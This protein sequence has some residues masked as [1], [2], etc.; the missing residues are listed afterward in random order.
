MLMLCGLVMTCGYAPP[1]GAAEQSADPDLI[2]HSASEYDYPPFS[3]IDGNGRPGGFSVDLFTAAVR[4][5]GRDV[6]FHVGPWAEVKEM[7]KSGEVDALPLVGRTPEREAV[8]DFTFP[9]LSLHGAIVVRTGEDQIRDLDDL[10]G[11]D[12]A[13]MKGDNAEEFLR[14]FGEDINISTTATFEDA[15]RE[16]SEGRHDAVV[17]QRLVALRLIR[18]AGITNLS[19]INKPL[20]G[21][22]QDFCFAVREGD[23]ET[24]ALLNEGLSL[25][26]ADGTFRYLNAKWFAALELP[27]NQR[28]VV[29]GDRNFPPFEFLDEH[30]LPAGYNVEITRAIARELGLDIEIRL[31]DWGEI[32]KGLASGA[33]DA[34]QGM[35]Y[36]AERDLEFDFS[37]PHTV[38]NYVA[39]VRKGTGDPPASPD[40]LTGK[41]LV[42]M[43]GDIMHDLALKQGLGG[44]VATV[45]SQEDALREL[46]EG[47]H[48]C[49]LVA[50][51]PAMYWIEKNGWD[52]LLVGRHSLISPE[53]CYAVPHNHQ[54]LLAQFSEG[55]KIIKETGEYRRIQKK[56]LG[57]YDDSSI[58]LVAI[59]RH[60]AMGAVP[61]LII[62][63]LVFFLVMVV[64]QTGGAADSGFGGKRTPIDNPDVESSRHGLPL[65]KRCRMDHGICQRRLPGSDRIRRR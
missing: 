32:R 11:R 23:K 26:M 15:L 53:Y 62:L 36:S 3:I 61:L 25:V 16:L 40:E 34:V 19:V 13:V 7:L 4:A 2:L 65:P 49:A 64:A 10:S 35:F 39:V 47:K 51:R 17:V 63:F 14:R 31:D 46:A 59:L 45:A 44:H 30:G 9:Y 27:S 58:S 18:A 22:Q 37:A 8:F 48:D 57:V 42:V 43:Q 55:L 21:F 33:I 56:W 5:M 38:I 6:S 20:K 12:V 28:I 41:R 24:L 50:R 52:D 1:A 60:V 29:G 54:A